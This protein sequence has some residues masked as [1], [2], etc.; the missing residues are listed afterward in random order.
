MALICLGSIAP[1]N[2]LKYRSKK[3]FNPMLSETYEYV[4]EKVRTLSEKV[5][6]DPRQITMTYLEGRQYKFWCYGWV[7]PAFKLYGGRGAFEISNFGCSDYYS[8]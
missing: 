7:K 8:K 4:N 5:E 2:T 6:H 3:P 1:L